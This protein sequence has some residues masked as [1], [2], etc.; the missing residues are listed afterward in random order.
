MI[1]HIDQ[2]DFAESALARSNIY[3]LL[4]IIYR[5]EP[6]KDL[7]KEIKSAQFEN[8]LSNLGVHFGEE[9]ARQ[10]EEKL[11]ETLAIEFARLFI[12]P[13][14]HISPHESV[15]LEGGKDGALWGDATVK[16]QQF[17]E[18]TGLSH[19]CEYR[20]LPDHISVELEFMQIVSKEAAQRWKKNDY[21][22][23]ENCLKI[24]QK[25]LKEHLS[26]WVPFFCNKVIKKTQ[27]TIY[28]ET[29]IFTKN[30]IKFACSTPMFVPPA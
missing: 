18:S 11:L 17:I 28:R 14:Q 30:F 22:G 5:E 26:K 23:S 7:I 25:F 12:G 1:N 2:N 3:G 20:G 16:V 27:L 24:E 8:A 10:P 9:F 4:A 15:H 19:K 29:A 21:Y 13:G 6:S